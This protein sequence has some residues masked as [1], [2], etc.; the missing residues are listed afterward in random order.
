M[1]N[2]IL[3]PKDVLKIVSDHLVSTNIEF[4]RIDLLTGGKIK[5]I[6]NPGHELEADEIIKIQNVLLLRTRKETGLDCCVNTIVDIIGVEHTDK[7]WEY[8]TQYDDSKINFS[9]LWALL[10]ELIS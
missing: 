6:F 2:Y 10:L 4:E 1:K 3:Y 5:V 9:K 7:V 8:V